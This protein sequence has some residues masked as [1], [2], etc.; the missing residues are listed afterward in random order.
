MSTAD[1]SPQIGIEENDRTGQWRRM[2]V[3]SRAELGTLVT[4]VVSS[5]L[6]KHLRGRDAQ[7]RSSLGHHMHREIFAGI[8]STARVVRALKRSEF[9]KELESSRDLIL[10]RRQRAREELGHWTRLAEIFRDSVS[11]QREELEKG[12]L[13]RGQVR[14][15]SLQK[16][17]RDLF[18]SARQGSID[19]VELHGKIE[20][21]TIEATRNERER[22]SEERAAEHRLEVDLFRRR[23]TKLSSYL[24]KVE[25][26][27]HELDELPESEGIEAIRNIVGTVEEGEDLQVEVKSQMMEAVYR[28]NQELR[29]AMQV[30]HARAA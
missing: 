12:S 17:I 6:A 9:M 19:L 16:N 4:E 26:A 21:L 11:N 10:L 29:E 13:E 30:G 1:E 27:I 5:S 24:G 22:T 18:A 7:M 28:S 25:H 3:I 14:E 2:S 8:R 20:Q 23:I 15:E